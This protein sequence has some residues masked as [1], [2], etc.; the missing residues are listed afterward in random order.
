MPRYVWQ[1]LLAISLLLMVAAGCGIATSG[2]PDDIGSTAPAPAPAP[3]PSLEPSPTEATDDPAAFAVPPASRSQAALARGGTRKSVPMRLLVDDV[4][5]DAPL[6]PTGVREDGL[7]E[8]PD[9]GD[10]AGWYQYGPSPGAGSGS[11]VL[12]GHVDTSEG[13]GAMAALRDVDLGAVVSVEMSDGTSQRYEIIGRETVE[14]D[15]LPTDEIFDR[16]G[17]ERLT[18]ITC[19]GPWRSEASSYRDNVVVVATPID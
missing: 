2:E 14:K 9:D 1:G 11:V 13:L 10:R 16:G 12:A 3:A 15:D 19:G 7:M 8:I 18:L 6:D 17:P 4:E 5:L